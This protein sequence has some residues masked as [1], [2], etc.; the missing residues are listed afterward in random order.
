MTHITLSAAEVRAVL[1]GSK[2][3]FRKVL[4]P[5]PSARAN[6]VSV[7]REQWMSE[8]PS[9]KGG[10][11]QWDPWRK[12]PYAPGDEVWVRETWT[13]T[14]EGVWTVFDARMRGKSGVVYRAD[15]DTPGFKWFSAAQMP[16]EF[17]R[18][19]LLVKSVRVERLQDISEADAIAEGCPRLIYSGDGKFHEHSGGSVRVGFMG[20]WVHRHG[21]A[22]WDANP[23]VEVVE[24]ER[25]GDD[26]QTNLSLVRLR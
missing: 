24:F 19:T 22:S 16:C 5:Q 10:T 18:I 6:S 8:G 7:C 11:L 26:Q 15:D 20:C 12:L 9:L 17:S 21:A 1:D 25:R 23:W 3:Q 13:H 14:G 2:T 4:K